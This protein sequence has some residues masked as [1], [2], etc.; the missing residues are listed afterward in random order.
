MKDKIWLSS[1]H[2][3][4]SEF[5]FVKEAFETNWISPVGPHIAAFEKELG[6]YLNTPHVAALSSGTAAIH[7][8]LILLKVKAGDEV[9][10]SSFTFS[11]SVN[12]V[13]YQGAEPVFIDSERDTWNMDPELLEQAINDRTKAGKKPKAIIVVHLYGTPA[14]LKQIMEIAARHE[15]PVIEDAAEALGSTYAGQAAGTFGDFGIL[16]FNGNKIITTSGGG[17]LVSGNKSHIDKARFLATQARDPAPH[18]EHTEIGYNYRLSNICA[19]I[20]RGQLQVLDKRVAQ[21]RSNFEFYRKHLSGLP[22]TFPQEP[23]ECVC[24][25]WLTTVTISP[26]AGISREQI[27]QALETEN[28]ETRPVWKPMHRQPVF[29]SCKSYVNGV[30]DGIFENGLC[31]PSGSNM[32]PGQLERVVETIRSIM[33]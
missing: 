29:S 11:G 27:R 14:K 9:I 31:L 16:S 22:M 21:R 15:I 8:A 13:A 19:G 2:M 30:S 10:C 18:Y 26:E 28:I 20:G 23:V 1:P 12:P 25:R 24:N 3:E 6:S 4:G 33:Q 7:L 32:S 17:A 5:E